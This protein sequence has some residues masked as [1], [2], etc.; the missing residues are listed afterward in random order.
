MAGRYHIVPGLLRPLLSGKQETVMQVGLCESWPA[1]SL[2]GKNNSN[3]RSHSS[4]FSARLL[5]DARLRGVCVCVSLAQCACNNFQTCKLANYIIY[6]KHPW[7]ALQ[8]GSYELKL[9][10]VPLFFPQLF[11]FLFWSPVCLPLSRF[12]PED[13]R[14]RLAAVG[15]FFLKAFISNSVFSNSNKLLAPELK[16]VFGIRSVTWKSCRVPV[17]SLM[18]LPCPL[19]PSHWSDWTFA[20]SKA[21]G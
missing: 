5:S 14:H 6:I 12:I 8:L 21:H 19:N 9:K 17:W 4:E 13:V 3:S 11:I 16:S 7:Q 15:C 1:V 2:K 10:L 20:R 18:H